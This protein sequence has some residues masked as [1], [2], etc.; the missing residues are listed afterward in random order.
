VLESSPAKLARAHALVDL[1]AALRRGNERA[2]ARDPLRAGLDLA[3]RCGATGLEERAVQ[4]LET[5]GA[6]PRRR[7]ISGVDALTPSERRV[8]E[9]AAQGLSNR[10]IAQALFL[11]VRTIEN[12]LRQVYLKLDVAGRRELPEALAGDGG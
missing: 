7:V 3:H 10:D 8:A 2:A 12:Q 11:S 6:R 1:G 9:M 5:A 4:E